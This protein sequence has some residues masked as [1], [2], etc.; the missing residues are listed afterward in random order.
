[1][2][3]YIKMSPYITYVYIEE[4]DIIR[5]LLDTDPDINVSIL[6]KRCKITKIEHIATKDTIDE[7]TRVMSNGLTYRFI[8]NCWFNKKIF[9]FQTYSRAFFEGFMKRQ[10]DKL[11]ENGYSG[12]CNTYYKNGQIEYEG[13]INN[14][15]A[16]GLCRRYF[17]N[18]K[19]EK[20]GTIINGQLNGELKVFIQNHKPKYEYKLKVHRE[21]VDG[22][23]VKN[24]VA[25]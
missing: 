13:N 20:E 19:V 22:V 2:Q 18:G 14:G 16:Y 25:S 15:Q 23:I 12:P 5:D 21:Y 4:K 6:V 10:E 1:M 8:V 7:I 3:A 24:Y 9:V 11:F 17:E